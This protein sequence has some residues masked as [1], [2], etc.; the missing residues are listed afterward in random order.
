MGPWTPEGWEEFLSNQIG[1][2]R[3]GEK[4]SGGGTRQAP[5]RVSG[6]EG[7]FPHSEEP[8]HHQGRNLWE[9]GNRGE[10]SQRLLCPLSPGESVGV[11]GLKAPPPAGTPPAAQIS[12]LRPPGPPTT[13]GLFQTLAS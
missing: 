1:C 10:H 13:P 6:G 2:G 8:T 4:K 9:A 11:L 3:E 5:L 12:G 7:R